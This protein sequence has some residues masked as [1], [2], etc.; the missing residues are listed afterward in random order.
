M[1]HGRVDADDEIERR[2]ERGGVGK[3]VQVRGSVVK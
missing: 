3:V 1:D 2:H